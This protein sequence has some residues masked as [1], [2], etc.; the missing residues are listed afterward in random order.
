MLA[1]LGLRSYTFGSDHPSSIPRRCS[2]TT[3]AERVHDKSLES[4]SSNSISRKVIHTPLTQIT[5]HLPR[6]GISLQPLPHVQ[7]LSHPILPGPHFFPQPLFLVFQF[8]TVRL[9]VPADAERDEGVGYGVEFA[10][11]DKRR[12]RGENGLG[13]RWRLARGEGGGSCGGCRWVSGRRPGW[14]V[15]RARGGLGRG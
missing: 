15:E 5:P 12:E 9:E 7:R 1:S 14:G 10:A 6:L 2:I 4:R 11:G 8:S 3:A 13:E